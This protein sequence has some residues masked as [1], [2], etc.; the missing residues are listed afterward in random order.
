MSTPGAARSTLV[1]PKFEKDG[2]L[3]VVIV[4]ATA[5]TLEASG[6]PGRRG[7][8]D[9]VHVARPVAGRRHE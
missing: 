6:R 2:E 4:A 9:P 7:A 5:T 8:A 3:V 1:L